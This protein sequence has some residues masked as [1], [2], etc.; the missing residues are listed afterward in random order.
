M[1]QPM[2]RFSTAASCHASSHQPSRMLRFRPPLGSTFMPLVPL[3]SWGRIVFQ[4]DQAAAK[5]FLLSQLHHLLDQ[6]LTRIVA[7]MRF[8]G[9]QD[10]YRPARLV[11]NLL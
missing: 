2:K 7:R 4:E 1:A 10:L 11:E 8:A 6:R 3:A 5:F 9:K